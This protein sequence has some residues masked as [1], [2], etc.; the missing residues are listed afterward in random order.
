MFV[1][2][3][4]FDH[5]CDGCQTQTAGKTGDGNGPRPCGQRPIANQRQGDKKYKCG[6][7]KIFDG[8]GGLKAQ[9]KFPQAGKV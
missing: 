9:H 4:N 6:D 3:N 2:V 8:C 7:T 5:D 1:A